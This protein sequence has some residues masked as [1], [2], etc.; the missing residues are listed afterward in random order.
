MQRYPPQQPTPRGYPPQQPTP[1]PGTYTQYPQQLPP[2]QQQQGQGQYVPFGGPP[3]PPAKKKSRKKLYIVIGVI[4]GIV[5]IGGVLS[6]GGNRSPSDAS[7]SVPTP[8][9]TAAPTQQAKTTNTAP[10]GSTEQARLGASLPAFIARYG[11]PNDHTEAGNGDYH[12]ARYP[13]ENTDSIIVHTDIFDSGS[14]ARKVE[15]VTAAAPESNWTQTQSDTVCLALLPVDAHYQSRVQLNSAT[16]YDKIYYSASLAKTFPA[17]AFTDT[18]NNPTRPGLFDVQY[19]T[20]S[21][22]TINDCE[23]SLGTQQEI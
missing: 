8:V 18:N 23:L 9:P 6:N 11:Q 2:A 13:G 4:V 16:G 1:P 5:L 12:F 15:D 22:G 10:A 19:L 7:S 14:Y 3:M 17:D 21:D 20:N